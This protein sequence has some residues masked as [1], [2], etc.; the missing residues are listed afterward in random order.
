MNILVTGAT[1][2]SIDVRSRVEEQMAIHVADFL[3]R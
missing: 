2:Y 1:V 3:L